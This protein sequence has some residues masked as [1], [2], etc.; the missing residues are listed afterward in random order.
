[1]TKD[2]RKKRGGGS[3]PACDNCEVQTA[4]Q[5]LPEKGPEPKQWVAF[6]KPQTLNE[7]YA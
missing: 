1:M 6:I 4:N 2:G 3:W 7:E 5:E